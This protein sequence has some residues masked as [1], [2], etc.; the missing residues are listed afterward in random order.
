MSGKYRMSIKAAERQAAGLRT[1]IER[2]GTPK[3]AAEA[4]A[5]NYLKFRLSELEEAIEELEKKNCDGKKP[6]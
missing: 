1:E 4:E 6:T 3:N 5:K 2:I